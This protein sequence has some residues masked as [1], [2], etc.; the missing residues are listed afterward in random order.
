MHRNKN[1]NI[2][3]EKKRSPSKEIW[4]RRKDKTATQLK[5]SHF[6]TINE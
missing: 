3:I 4:S 5:A 2:Q 1:K 6:A